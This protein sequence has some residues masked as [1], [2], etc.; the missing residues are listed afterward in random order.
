MKSVLGFRSSSECH[1]NLGLNA[2]TGLPG[3]LEAAPAG[4]HLE[5]QHGAGHGGGKSVTRHVCSTPW[6]RQATAQ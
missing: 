3:D 6:S 4:G 5:A 2:S 1:F